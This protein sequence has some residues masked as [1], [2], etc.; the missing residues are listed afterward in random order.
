MLGVSHMSMHE[1]LSD[2]DLTQAILDHAA[3]ELGQVIT[4]NEKDSHSSTSFKDY[5]SKG[6]LRSETR[7]RVR[8]TVDQLIDCKKLIEK[9]LPSGHPARHGRRTTALTLGS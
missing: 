6:P 5:L 1:P 3:E 9:E 4:D 7:K 2:A 8:A